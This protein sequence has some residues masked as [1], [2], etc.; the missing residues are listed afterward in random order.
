[1]DQILEASSDP[2]WVFAI[3][4]VVL[5]VCHYFLIFR[6]PLTLKQ[7]KLVEFMWVGLALVSIFGIIEQ[8]R[9]FGA[10]VAVEQSNAE[11]M[12]KIMALENW[13]DVYRDF[14]C[15]EEDGDG[16]LAQLCVWTKVKTSD[17]RL[18]L[19]NEDSPVDIPANFLSGMENVMGGLAAPDQAIVRAH[20]EGYLVARAKYLVALSDG[21]RSIFS[22]WLVAF[23]PMI[24]AI[25]VAIKFTKVTGEYRLCP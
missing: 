18:I 21:E 24:F 8:A 5:V 11:A 9:F 6:Y 19:E 2:F 10:K 1:M 13:F 20:H 15:E 22:I 16:K 25:A 17:L 23:A 4:A 3:F 14:A 7:W 12:K